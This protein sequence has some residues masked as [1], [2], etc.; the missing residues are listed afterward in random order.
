[1]LYDQLVEERNYA[2]KNNQNVVY[3]IATLLM[4]E[5]DT[6]AKRDNTTVTDEKVVSVA[7]K[8][9]KS[10]NETIKL[11]KDEEKKTRLALQNQFLQKF[12]PVMISEEEIRKVL[13]ESVFGSIPESFK[14]LDVKFKGCYDRGVASKVAKEFL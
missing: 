11:L 14:A 13:S 4:G 7:S 2:R 9:I 8:L 1:M 3:D 12:L 5:L 6:L 10:N